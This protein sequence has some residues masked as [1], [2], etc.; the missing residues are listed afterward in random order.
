MQPVPCVL[1]ESSRGA[2]KRVSSRPVQRM[3]VAAP[4]RWPPLTR[5]LFGPSF[6]MRRAAS[7]MS[8]SVATGISASAPASWR[9]GVTTS[10]SGSTASTSAARAAG[11]SS[12]SPDF[13]IITGSRTIRSWRYARRRSA[14]APTIGA[15]ESMPSFTAS[16]PKSSSTES[17]CRA[18]NSGGRSNTPWTPREF[19]AV[20]AVSTDMPKTRKAEKVLRS[21]W[22]PAPPPE[23]DPAMVSALGTSMDTKVYS[24]TRRAGRPG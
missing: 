21:A 5:T 12:A 9:F 4:A 11:W 16:A 1:A 15:V 23:S 13:A 6:R 24:V 2:V 19:W 17:I 14:T 7:S 20:T 22:M 10:A 3:S 8:A 18:T